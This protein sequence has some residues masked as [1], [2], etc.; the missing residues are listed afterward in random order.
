MILN[1][2]QAY[3]FANTKHAFNE[4]PT[5]KIGFGDD[6]EKAIFSLKHGLFHMLRVSYLFYYPPAS[7]AAGTS[8]ECMTIPDKELSQELVD[9]KNAIL[10]I[11]VNVVSM[12]KIIGLS[13]QALANEIEVPDDEEMQTII[14]GFYGPVPVT[15][16]DGITYFML[17]LGTDLEEADHAG[18]LNVQKVFYNI[19]KT[20]RIL[21]YWLGD[22]WTPEF[23]LQVS[24]L[25]EDASKGL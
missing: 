15:L 24:K 22:A 4:K 20:Y 8:F 9:Y 23:L 16:K 12:A 10:D 7:E 21:L 3:A 2:V 5:S 14:A 13:E 6:D 11:I 25:P 17:C 1:F 18:K 19:L